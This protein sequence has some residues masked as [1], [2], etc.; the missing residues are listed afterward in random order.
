MGFSV[1]D[2]LIS[3]LIFFVLAIIIFVAFYRY[4]IST[5]SEDKQQF[6]DYCQS[7]GLTAQD[8]K[9]EWVR[10]EKG[11]SSQFILILPPP[12]PPWASAPK[13]T[14]PAI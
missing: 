12:P 11:G 3:V 1:S 9:W 8:C 13:A 14:K 2:R 7:K 5:A 4:V 10:M 6:L